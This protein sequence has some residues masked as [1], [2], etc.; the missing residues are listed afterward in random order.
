MLITGSRGLIGSALVAHFKNTFEIL[1]LDLVL[2]H[3]LVDEVFVREWFQKN[4]NLY[5]MIVCHAYNPIAPLAN[6]K[7]K[8]VEPYAVPLDELRNYFEIN[9]ISAFDVCRNFIKNN[10]RGVIINVSSI[11]GVASPKHHLY[12]NFAKP[13]GYSMSKAAVHMMTKYLAT[14]YAPGVRVN[15]VVLGGVP[16]GKQNTLFLAGYNRHVPLGRMMAVDEVLSVF[17][18]LLDKRS[19]YVTGTEIFVDGGWTA[20]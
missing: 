16:A 17:D 11:Y 3:D 6:T 4:K 19:S 5:G 13:I 20:W 14:Y 10:Q 12:T 9:S 7:S 18:F 15:T 1:E 8:K 2:G